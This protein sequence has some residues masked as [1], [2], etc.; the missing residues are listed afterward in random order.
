MASGQIRITLLN[1]GVEISPLRLRGWLQTEAARINARCGQ[2]DGV[3]LR[4]F[5]TKT[6][7]YAFTGA[8]LDT[9]LQALANKYPAIQRIETQLV[10]APLDQ[11]QM[12]SQTREAN[13]RLAAFVK[14]AQAHAA[15]REAEAREAEIQKQ[16]T[17]IHWHTSALDKK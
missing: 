5:L 7:R 1:P 4:L 17:P 10:D 8:K 16:L 12:E 3:I 13:A 6:L 9:L 2:D 11:A 15:K 14:L